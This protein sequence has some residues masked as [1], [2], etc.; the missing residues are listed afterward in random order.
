[1]VFEKI[2]EIICDQLGVDEDRI[3]LETTFEELGADSLDLFQV[4]IEIEE[5]YNIQLEEAESIKTVNDAVEYVES[6][7]EN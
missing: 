1:M 6:K 4:I 7:I 3:T 5:A 2:K